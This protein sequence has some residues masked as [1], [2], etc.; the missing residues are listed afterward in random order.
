LACE[1]APTQGPDDVASRLVE[2]RNLQAT[3][4]S[5]IQVSPDGPYLVTNA[6]NVRNWLGQ[7]LPARPQM[8]LCRCGESQRKPLCDGTHARIGF[9]GAKDPKR[10]T[11]RRDSYSGQQVTIFD[12]RGICQ[13]SGYCSDR[14]ASVFH[15]DGVPFVTP[16]GGRLDDLIR[17]VRN[18]PSGALSYAVDDV[19]ARATVDHHSRREPGIEV[20]KDGPYR[21]TGGIPLT[22]EKGADEPRA[23]GSSREHYA[24]CRCG[25]SQNKPFC[26]GMHW[27]VDFKDPQPAAGRPSLFEWAGGLPALTTLA[28]LFYEKYVPGDSLLAPLF[29]TMP[30]D[31]TQ[32]S[33][34]WL[35]E[36][37]GGPNLYSEQFGGGQ[38]LGRLITQGARAELSEPARMRW[39][40]LMHQCADEAGLPGDAE[41]RSAFASYI[42]WDSVTPGE[43][44]P[45]AGEKSQAPQWDWGA[46]G[47]PAV[48]ARAQDESQELSSMPGPD[49]TVSFSRHIKPLF[50]SRDRQSMSFAFDLWS[51][52]DVRSNANAILERVQN[53]SMPCDGA[54]PPERVQVFQRWLDSGMPE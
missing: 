35:A 51:Y 15:A 39:A 34:A 24:L 14:L 10:V 52:A 30:S 37:F 43:T 36:V 19:E 49:E 8:A 1:L 9:T 18:C 31:Q 29:A 46:A 16:S 47:P 53:G 44:S 33:A 3:V 25:H 32:R 4:P 54:W 6:E 11:D 27:Y 48:A 40:S 12:N 28:R 41:F 23:D 26:S 45:P 13:H 20:S 50:R 38:R 7:Q 17:A 22:D 42:Q 5:G 2:L 21:V